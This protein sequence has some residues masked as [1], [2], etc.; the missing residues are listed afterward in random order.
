MCEG[1]GVGCEGEEGLVY[2]GKGESSMTR[3]GQ[4][5]S[6]RQRERRQNFLPAPS[7]ELLRGMYIT[8]GFTNLATHASTIPD[9]CNS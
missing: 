1:G 2:D 3:E 7:K 9:E 5:W 8:Y 4:K 6:E